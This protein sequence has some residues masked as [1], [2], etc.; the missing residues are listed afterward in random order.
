M[1]QAVKRARSELKA[2]TGLDIS[3][4][5]RAERDGDGWLVVIEAVE[6]H[7]IPEGM[8]ILASY[9]TRLDGEGNMVEFRRI[10]MRKRI[11]TEEEMK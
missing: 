2:V 11:D 5:I 10:G 7:S 9:E 8:D 1:G 4:T 6:K 3:S